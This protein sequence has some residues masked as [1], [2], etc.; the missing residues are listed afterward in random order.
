[1]KLNHLVSKEH[2]R[3]KC[4]STEK[5]HRWFATGAVESKPG[6]YVAV[7]FYCKLCEKRIW[8]F[9]TTEQYDRYENQLKVSDV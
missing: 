7:G 9:L 8:E 6:E 3:G 2:Q 4:G 5:Q 1:M